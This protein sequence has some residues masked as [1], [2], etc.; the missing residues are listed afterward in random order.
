MSTTTITSA[1]ATVTRQLVAE[2]RLRLDDTVE[3]WQPGLVPNGENITVGTT[4]G[5]DGRAELQLLEWVADRR[6]GSWWAA[7]SRA[8]PGPAV[9]R[10]RAARGCGTAG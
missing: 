4:A 9:P 3:R 6:F 2:R 8:A 7:P 1:V 10:R 5:A